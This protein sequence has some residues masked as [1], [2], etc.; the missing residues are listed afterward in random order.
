MRSSGRTWEPREARPPGRGLRSAPSWLLA[1]GL[2][3]LGLLPAGCG[4][5]RPPPERLRLRVEVSAGPTER[6]LERLY[7]VEVVERDSRRPVEGAALRL[8]ADMPSMPGAHTIPPVEASPT[9][10][11]GRYTARLTLDMPGE[12]VVFVEVLR[13]VRDRVVYTDV[14]GADAIDRQA[15]SGICPECA[16]LP[17]WSE[18]VTRA[19]PALLGA[20]LGETAAERKGC[21][22]RHLEGQRRAEGLRRAL[23]TLAAAVAT[24]PTMLPYGHAL[25]HGLAEASHAAVGAR[26]TLVQ[27]LEVLWGGCYHGVLERH[28]ATS[29][30]SPRLAEICGEPASGRLEDEDRRCLNGLGRGL[31]LLFGFDAARA[32]ARCDGFRTQEARATCHEGVLEEWV[33]LVLRRRGPVAVGACREVPARYAEP[34]ARVL[35]RASRP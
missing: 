16:G 3:A 14:V 23:L 35:A 22:G 18:V 5:E 4:S 25:A 2:G 20:C 12:W 24:D 21:W 13:P 33:E 10:T 31:L 30:R 7:T 32:L 28:V 11:P 27:C 1:L 6:P 26:E 8:T 17:E 9:E 29:L 34:C 15:V 19:L